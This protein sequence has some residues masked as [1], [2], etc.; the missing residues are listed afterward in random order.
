M[1]AYVY[2]TRALSSILT[3]STIVLQIRVHRY[4]AEYVPIYRIIAYVLV[5]VLLY[6]SC[7]EHAL[8]RQL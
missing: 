5:Y 6:V 4:A 2:L 3:S 1:H 7:L 8:L